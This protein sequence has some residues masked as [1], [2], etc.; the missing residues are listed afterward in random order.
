MSSPPLDVLLLV[1]FLL[2]MA[3]FFYLFVTGVLNR[4]RQ[5]FRAAALAFLVSGVL[6]AVFLVRVVL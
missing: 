2:L 1:V 5:L 4:E 6:A 3:G